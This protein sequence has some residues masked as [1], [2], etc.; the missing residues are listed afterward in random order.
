MADMAKDN[1]P[2]RPR[3]AARRFAASS[4]TANIHAER[5]PPFP[6]AHPEGNHARIRPRRSRRRPRHHPGQHQSSRTR[7]DDHRAQFPR[8]DQRQYRQQRRRV[9]HRGGSRENALGHQ[10]GRGHRHGPVHRQ[11]HPRHARMDSA[12]LAR[13]HRHRADLSGARKSRRQGRRTHLGNFPRHPHRT[14]RAG[15]GLFHHPRR[16]AAALHPAHRQSHDRHRQPR[17]QHHGQM[18][19]RA[20]P[21]KFPL[22]PLG[23]HLRHHG[24]V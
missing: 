13:A 11:E 19:P 15:R 3:Q 5:L 24:R 10:V 14:G 6:A 8:E 7:A 2:Q 4:R 21:G 17:R 1:R 23:R 12:Q 20:S 22:H 9:E 18:V 16:R